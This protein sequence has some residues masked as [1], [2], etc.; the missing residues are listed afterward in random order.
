MRMTWVANDHWWIYQYITHFCTE[1]P[2]YCNNSTAPSL[3]F[4]NTPDPVV[5]VYDYTNFTCNLGYVSSAA[6]ILPYYACEPLNAVAG[7]WSAVN[8]SC[9]R[10]QHYNTIFSTQKALSQIHYIYFLWTPSN[11]RLLRRG[12]SSDNS[13]CERVGTSNKCR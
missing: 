13:E 10:K 1:I 9:L 2:V 3:E 4:A 6:P 11:T 12:Y 8:Y 5:T 7:V